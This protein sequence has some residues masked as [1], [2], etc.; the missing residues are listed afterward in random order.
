MQLY[1]IRHGKTQWNLERRLQGAFGDSPLL[2]ESYVELRALGKYLHKV[3]FKKIYTSPSLRARKTAQGIYAH[4][5]V[6]CEIQVEEGLREFGLGQLEGATFEEA[7]ARFPEQMKY[8]RSDLSKFNPSIF[9][10]EMPVD[11][12]K[13]A[14]LVVKKALNE[15]E[16]GPILFVSHGSTLTALVQHLAGQPLNK[17]RS[18][19]GLNNNTINIMESHEGDL[20]FELVTWNDDSFL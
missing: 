3:P 1:F 20:P 5:D 16:E 13:R 17:L 12:L 6:P 15:N 4:L 14:S 8:F 18:S 9:G 10:G 19:G 11:V 2:L 7:K